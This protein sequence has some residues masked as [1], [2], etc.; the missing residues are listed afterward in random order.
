MIPPVTDLHYFANGVQGEEG[1]GLAET[2][3][4]M[5]PRQL[6]CKIAG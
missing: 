5:N 4:D 6:G 1:L 2:A 3:R